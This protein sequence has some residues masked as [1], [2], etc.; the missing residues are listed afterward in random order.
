MTTRRKRRPNKSKQP[1]LGRLDI[2]Y[3]LDGW[4]DSIIYP[5]RRGGFWS[6]YKFDTYEEAL[7]EQQK[8]LRDQKFRNR[9]FRGNALYSPAALRFPIFKVTREEV[10]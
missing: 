9:A 5:G 1:S 2:S 7:A 4:G 10:G 6:S 3:E 8:Q